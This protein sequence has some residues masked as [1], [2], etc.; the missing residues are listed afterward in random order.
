MT[1]RARNQSSGKWPFW[2]L[3]MAWFCANMPQTAVFTA[4]TWLAEVRS[5]PH[6]QRLTQDVARLLAGER[7]TSPIADAVARAQDELP[8][9][10]PTS[11]PAEGAT[12]KL[13]L[14][15]E[16]TCELLPARLRA[17]RAQGTAWTCPQPRRDAPP[18]RPPRL[19]L[20]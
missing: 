10:P 13:E 7:P 20:A 6:Q 3:L 19:S 16:T 8:A 12:K 18:H 5:F 9:R 11:L 14:L 2:L 4:L 1:W 17:S 15:L